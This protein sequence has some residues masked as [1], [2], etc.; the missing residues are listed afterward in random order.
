MSKLQAN[1][2]NWHKWSADNE[3]KFSILPKI[4]RLSAK[5]YT[6]SQWFNSQAQLIRRM[7]LTAQLPFLATE[8]LAGELLLFTAV[9]FLVSGIDDLLVDA[10]WLWQRFRPNFDK[11]APLLTD[12]YASD[13]P[14]IILLPAW[15]ES[16]VIA[17]SLRLMHERWAGQ[18]FRVY[19][20]CY[21]NDAPTILATSMAAQFAPSIRMVINRRYGPTSKADCL[22]QLWQALQNDV[23]DGVIAP[24]AVVLHDAEDIVHPDALR[25]IRAGLQQ[26]DLV[27]LPVVPLRSAHSLWISGHYADEFA[28]MHGKQM[29]VR[30]FIGA[31][32][33]SAGVGCAVRYAVAAH[34]SD[35]SGGYPFDA[36]SLTE[37]YLLGIGLSGAG[38]RTIFVRAR[39]AQGQLI[40]T[41]ELFP[42][43]LSGAVRQKARWLAGIAFQ[44]WDRLGWSPRWYENWA[45]LHDRKASL[46]A[47]VLTL[48]YLSIMLWTLLAAAQLLGW[49]VVQPISPLLNMLL[50]LNLGFLFWRMAVRAAFVW[51]QY[52]PWQA[53]LSVPRLFV[54]NIVN[55]MAGRRAFMLYLRS[56]WG[57][58]M[59]WEKTD[60]RCHGEFAA[61]PP[62]GGSAAQGQP[63]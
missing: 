59:Q 34:L 17:H 54:G 2:S 53:L 63:H 46:S 19:V 30:Q 62:V 7:S 26:A 56:L 37:D 20:G 35:R 24:V 44:G 23:R 45:R 1:F 50:L 61:R 27:Q 25:L 47:L 52:G 3:P 6:R 49:H 16:A 22:N 14:L 28:E 18:N 21:P 38:Y 10:I 32:V 11:P 33:P 15:H 48:A 4:R 55:I 40:A 31:G 57:R 9:C 13:E 36:G 39:D 51:R 5:G 60:H 12:D 58:V 29:P 8:W 43:S 42:E 41:A